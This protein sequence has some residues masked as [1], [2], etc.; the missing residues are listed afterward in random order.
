MSWASVS[1]RMK[2]VGFRRTTRKKYA[3]PTKSRAQTVG[4]AAPTSARWKSLAAIHTASISA[5]APSASHLTADARSIGT[6]IVDA[7]PDVTGAASTMLA[8]ETAMDG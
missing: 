7:A 4:P 8:S 5:I 2:K 6:G 1:V 3:A